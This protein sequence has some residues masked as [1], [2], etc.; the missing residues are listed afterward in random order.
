MQH[1]PYYKFDWDVTAAGGYAKDGYGAGYGGEALQFAQY[2]TRNA[3]HTTGNWHTQ[4]PK[5]HMKVDYDVNAM[6]YA[7]QAYSAPAYKADYKPSY[8]APSYSKPAY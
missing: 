8:S 3:D 1:V 4:L 7:A 6:A 5:G 2:E